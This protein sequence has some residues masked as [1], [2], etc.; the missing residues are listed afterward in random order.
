M[1]EKKK[2][3]RKRGPRG[4]T[5][6]EERAK[7][8]AP[9]SFIDEF[10]HDGKL[11][12]LDAV[13]AAISKNSV[14][15]DDERRSLTYLRM[16][17][18]FAFVTDLNMISVAQ[19]SQDPRFSHLGADILTKWSQEDIWAYHRENFLKQAQEKFLEKA[20]EITIKQ[21]LADLPILRQVSD[22][23]LA[24][25]LPAPHEFVPLE[26]HDRRMGYITVCRICG[27]PQAGCG[28][29][30]FGVDGDKLVNALAK[31]QDLMMLMERTVIERVLIRPDDKRPSPLQE[32]T[33][34]KE[35]FGEI[36]N[37][38]P[39]EARA[40]AHAILR[41][42]NSQPAPVVIDGQKGE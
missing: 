14:I 11:P 41:L 38:S 20:S 22:K 37:I 40:A 10:K 42:R 28:D 19:L 32:F 2:A 15:P 31:L 36:S 1:Q 33:A 30:F 39:D 25:L 3:G 8:K 24:K 7:R 35:K 12:V 16:Q 9:R 6:P 21:R 23:I 26:Y 29:P 13:E 4:P 17:A 34:D 5:T 18:R 27:N